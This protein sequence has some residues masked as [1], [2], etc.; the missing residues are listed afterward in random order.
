MVS[1][2]TLEGLLGKLVSSVN[3]ERVY[4]NLQVLEFALL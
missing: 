3:I 4:W 2:K 1:R